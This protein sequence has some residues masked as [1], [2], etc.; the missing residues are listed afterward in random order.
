[1]KNKEILILIVII[2]ILLFIYLLFNNNNIENFTANKFILV[3]KLVGGLGNRIYMILA[4]IGF[5]KKWNMDYYLLDSE[6]DDDPHSDNR[7]TMLNELS[8]LFPDIKYLN[9]SID[10]SQW[11]KIDEA[12]ITN[13]ISIDNNIIL[14]GYFQDEE[15]YFNNYKI[16]LNK[17]INNL[18]KNIDTNNLFFIQ[19][20][21]GDYI[22]TDYEL[23]LINY[24]KKTINKIK[25]Q[26]NNPQFL[27]ITNNIN[28]ADNYIKTHN[29][30]KNNEYFYDSSKNRLD[31][32][33]YITQ[34]KGGIC[35]NSS[36]SR[37]GAYFILNRNKN[38]IFYPNDVKRPMSLVTNWITIVEL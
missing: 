10:T 6:I 34:C 37:I 13:N 18:L 21:F 9:K 38:L 35:S 19:F 28:M 27:V 20:R 23:N 26:I 36:F 22:G 4:G 33:Y 1:M 31:T 32:L 15:K 2:L 8:T 3:S 25:E 30:F 14:S 12:D 11:K 24:Y 16:N 5:A 17:P 29:L 7:F